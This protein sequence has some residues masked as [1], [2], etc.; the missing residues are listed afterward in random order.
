MFMKKDW[1]YQ[2]TKLARS[3]TW[4]VKELSIR[5]FECKR[6]QASRLYSID[7]V[8]RGAGRLFETSRSVVVDDD[9]GEPFCLDHLDVLRAPKIGMTDDKSFDSDLQTFFFDRIAELFTRFV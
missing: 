9:F 7:E 5:Y 3:M 1:K 6:L 2:K 4:R 8:E